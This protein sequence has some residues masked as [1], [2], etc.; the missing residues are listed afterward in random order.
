MNSDDAV[1]VER[2]HR[3]ASTS[4][5]RR[6]IEL[7]PG[8]C[9][10]H[11]L[12]LWQEAI[13]FLTAGELDVECSRGERHRFRAGDTL[14]LARLPIRRAHNSGGAPTRLLAIWRT[15]HR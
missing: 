3:T 1:D 11:D 10:N 6:L 5:S 12:A 7:E 9:L 15:T 14:T 4:L 13:V 8:A 2:F